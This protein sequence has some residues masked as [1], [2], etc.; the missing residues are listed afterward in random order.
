LWERLPNARFSSSGS[1]LRKIS[2]LFK[3]LR[4]IDSNGIYSSPEKLNIPQ[5]VIVTATA[6]S[7]QTAVATMELTD[8]PTRI[9][10]L[11]WY[12]IAAGVLLAIGILETWNHLYRSPSSLIV[13][14]NPPLVTLDANKDEKFS[15]T[16]KVLGDSKGG[17][18]WSVDGGGEID[19]MGTFRK[20]TDS[21]STIDKMVKVT[22]KSVTNPSRD[23]I[24]IINVVSG[25]HLEIALC[26][27]RFFVP[28]SVV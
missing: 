2:Y 18:T 11:G 1:E 12:A 21:S 27:H 23:G 16:T 13:V 26:H 22:A 9:R 7:G 6:K 5:M 19:S 10:I 15:F 20:K 3:P 17:V 4:K 14:V 24:A 28:A 25:K 8:A